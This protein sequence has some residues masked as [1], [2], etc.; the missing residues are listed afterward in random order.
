MGINGR[1]PKRTGQVF[2]EVGQERKL[3]I[4]M[5]LELLGQVVTHGPFRQE[6]AQQRMQ[7]LPRDQW[8]LKKVARLCWNSRKASQG[9]SLKWWHGHVSGVK[10]QYVLSPS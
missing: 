2:A 9:G 8:L 3:V 1:C 4:W 6:A 10:G 7:L 5:D